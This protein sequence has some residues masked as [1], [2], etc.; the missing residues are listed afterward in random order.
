MWQ[1][2]HNPY[3]T[4]SEEELEEELRAAG[5]IPDKPDFDSQMEEEYGGKVHGKSL[6]VVMTDAGVLPI[7]EYTDIFTTFELW[8]GHTNFDVTHEISQLIEESEGVEVLH[9]LTRYRFMIGVAAL[10]QPRE[11][12]TAIN[13][14]ICGHFT[15]RN[16]PTPA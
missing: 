13:D 10:F 1:K 14:K 3:K 12:F 2:A 4:V 9:I 6:A 5:D 15:E 11:V 16:S 7:T 8:R